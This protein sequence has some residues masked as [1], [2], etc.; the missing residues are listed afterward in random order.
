VA[1]AVGLAC[2]HIW[3]FAGPRAIDCA[4]SAGIA[5][6]L[7]N[8]LRDLK[9][10]ARAGRVYL[11]LEDLA[12]CGYT[13]EQ[14]QRGDAN[15]NFQ[16][17]MELETH[18]AKD[19][20]RAGIGLLDCLQPEGQRIFAMMMATYRVLLLR[21]ERRPADVFIRRVRVGWPRRLW[22][23]AR[24]TFGGAKGLIALECNGEPPP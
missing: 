22:I 23:A 18:R 16:R 5:L 15:A 14:L 6:Q 20:Y 4:R 24:G 13:I 11:P 17:L 9:E 2:I 7:T 3:G 12:A 1:S 8:I 21:I 19:F 10:D